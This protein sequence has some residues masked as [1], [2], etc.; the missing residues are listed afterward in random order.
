VRVWRELV[1][2]TPEEL[3]APV[4]GL[5]AF[6]AWLSGDGALAW[7]AVERALRADPDHTLARLVGRALEGAVPPSAWRPVREA[8]E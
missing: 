2:R 3:A 6:A 5:L 1:R 4:A 8:A 7:C